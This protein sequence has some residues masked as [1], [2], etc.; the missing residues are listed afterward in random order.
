MENKLTEKCCPGTFLGEDCY[1]TILIA[2]IL[3][4]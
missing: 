2:E 1:K 3:A 4:G